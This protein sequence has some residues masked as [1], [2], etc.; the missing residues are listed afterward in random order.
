MREILLS[1]DPGQA[2]TTSFNGIRCRMRIRYNTFADRWFFDLWV[3]DVL[4]LSG[5]RIV[6]GVDLLAAF[7]L[8]IGALFAVDYAGAGAVPDRTA[9]PAR[10][11][12]LYQID[13][14]ELAEVLAA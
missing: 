7:G 13:P 2:F 6:T 14:D 8:G 3:R 9:L 11:V 5:R 10:Q 4:M 12:R 1:T